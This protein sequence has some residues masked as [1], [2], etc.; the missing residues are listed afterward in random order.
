MPESEWHGARSEFAG[1]LLL[2]G[3]LAVVVVLFFL[4]A[5]QWPQVTP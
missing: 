3:L 4:L 5:G 1:T 2:Y